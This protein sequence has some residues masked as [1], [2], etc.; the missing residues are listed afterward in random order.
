MTMFAVIFSGYTALISIF[1]CTSVGADNRTCL[2]SEKR[3]VCVSAGCVRA[4]SEV[5]ATIDQ[6]VN[7]CDDFYQF[8]CGSFIK[9]S[10][11]PEDELILMKNV[12]VHNHVLEQLRALIEE[13]IRKSEPNAFVLLKK[14][15]NVCMDVS[16]IEEQDLIL[17]KKYLNDV[18]GWPVLDKKAIVKNNFDWK[19][20][21]Y[22]IRKIGFFHSGFFNFYVATN[23][24]N[25]SVNIITIDEGTTNLHK[26][27]LKEGFDNNAVR[28]YYNFIVKFAILFGANENYARKEVQDMVQFEIALAKLLLPEE[29]R[30]NI[31]ALTHQMSIEELE[32]AFPQ[33]PWL[34]YITNVLGIP[35]LKITKDEPVDVIVPSFIPKVD[36][37]LRQTPKR[38]LKN[39]IAWT[40]I[41]EFSTMLPKRVRDLK[42][43]FAQMTNGMQR[44]PPRWKECVIE[45]N[46]RMIIATSALYV[47][48]YFDVTLKRNVVEMVDD[49]KRSFILTLK[50]L[51]WMDEST[52]S[53]AIE[54]AKGMVDHVAYPEEIMDDKRIELY[55][56]Q[57]EFSEKY[58]DLYL[59]YQK[60][61]LVKVFGS[62]RKPV[63]KRD[64]VYHASSTAVNAY[65]SVSENGIELPA[66]ILQDLFFSN[67]RPQYMNY[68]GIGFIIGHEITHGFDDQGRQTDKDGRLVDWWTK[69][70]EETFIKKAQCF[71]D[72]YGKFTL[73]DSNVTVN[74]KNT[75]GE[76]IADN[77]SLKVSYLAY[78]YWVKRNR[79][80][81]FL[82]G[83]NYTPNQMFWITV[84][85]VWCSK[86]RPEILEKMAMTASHSPPYFR[87]LGSMRNSKYFA[88]DFNC[89]LGS[90]MNPK[91]KC[92]V[93]SVVRHSPKLNENIVWFQRVSTLAS[94]PD[95][96]DLP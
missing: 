37:L 26:E 1:I 34:D 41:E 63:S 70:T 36:E 38:V 74:G 29:E 91:D 11:I 24:L 9:N 54:K 67:D 52:R 93:C 21:I 16:A 5:L 8:A 89:A 44:I 69:K 4:A 57:L 17:A 40:F 39:F 94:G 73:P 7:P 14:M 55:Y 96:A 58:L 49:V 71:V 13:P 60:F 50:S 90:N 76:N 47:R 3:R 35:S 84:A 6:S 42:F 12:K 95:R 20:M 77:G 64:W 28:G 43:E 82:P 46:S 33:M 22:K 45:V 66:G 68:G 72:Q 23:L 75:L 56:A 92:S 25:T 2:D 59:N 30:R 62:L 15:Y 32:Q 48:K 78:Q 18:G 87:V 86:E 85:N 10:V 61:F 19:S 79:K 31:S 83:L 88:N 51:D 81:A 27:Y 80:E 65:Y 53:H